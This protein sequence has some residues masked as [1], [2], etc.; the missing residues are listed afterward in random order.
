MDILVIA[1]IAAG[2]V[3]IALYYIRNKKSG[4]SSAC[5]YGCNGCP[6]VMNC[7]GKIKPSEN[8]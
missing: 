3:A 5:G 7:P 6:S 1:I 2:L 8:D 4:K